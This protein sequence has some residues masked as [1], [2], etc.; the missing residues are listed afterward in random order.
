MKDSL[1]KGA[2]GGYLEVHSQGAALLPCSP[3]SPRDPGYTLAFVFWPQ[4]PSRPNRLQMRFQALRLLPKGPVL[5]LQRPFFFSKKESSGH[6][7]ANHFQ[8]SYDST[9]SDPQRLYAA[10][11]VMGQER[12]QRP[13]EELLGLV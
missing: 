7:S 1:G 6:V 3:P 11:R 9:Q 8:G 13:C 4:F 5:W 10:Q 2:A 12:F